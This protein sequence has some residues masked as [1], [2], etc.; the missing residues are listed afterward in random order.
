MK[1]DLYTKAILTVI[2]VSLIWIAA[3]DAFISRALGQA[4]VSVRVVG[5]R[6]DYKTD[7]TSGPTLKVC[8]DC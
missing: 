8:T 7:R 6:L 5:G 4:V 2:A 1:V 3:K